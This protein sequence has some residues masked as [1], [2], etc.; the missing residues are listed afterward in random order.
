LQNNKNNPIKKL[1]ADNAILG[2]LKN[3]RK[4]DAME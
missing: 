1:K 3:K 2:S 4:K